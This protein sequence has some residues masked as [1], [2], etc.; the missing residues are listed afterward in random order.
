MARRFLDDIRAD[1]ISLLPDNTVGSITPAIVRGLLNDIIA[2]TVQ[3]EVAMTSPP[4]TVLNLTPTPTEYP[5]IF[6]AA[7]GNV[8][9]F[10]TGNFT[11]GRFECSATPGWS[12]RFEFYLQAEGGQNNELGFQIMRN[13]V[14][15]GE[16]FEI[17]TRGAG[18][19]V[20]ASA[21][22]YEISA[23]ANATYSIAISSPGSDT[24]TITNAFA[25]AAIVPTNN[26]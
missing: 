24:F 22:W 7:I 5:Q 20:T 1:I 3:D 26:P 9:G 12:Y 8:P 25:L 19:G 16:R 10:L 17:I 21:A 15:V 2:S 13:G 14:V 18:R 11:T 6:Q 23:P 4:S